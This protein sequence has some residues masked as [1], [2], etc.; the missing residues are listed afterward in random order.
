MLDS[1]AVRA[2]ALDFEGPEKVSVGNV[3]TKLNISPIKVCHSTTIRWLTSLYP[4]NSA[5]GRW[6]SLESS[7][8]SG[9]KL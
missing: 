8:F 4:A 9:C 5:L 2:N 7:L 6:F 3:G 1:L